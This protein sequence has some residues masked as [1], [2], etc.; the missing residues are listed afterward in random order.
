[1][2]ELKLLS[3]PLNY[4]NYSI[5]KVRRFYWKIS[6]FNVTGMGSMSVLSDSRS[7]LQS[8]HNFNKTRGSSFQN[9]RL[10]TTE[11]NWCSHWC[12]FQQHLS[13]WSISKSLKHQIADLIEWFIFPL[14]ESHEWLVLRYASEL[15]RTSL[16]ELCTWRCLFRWQ[17]FMA[18]Q[19]LRVPDSLLCPTAYIYTCM[20]TRDTRRDPWTSWACVRHV[21]RACN[22]DTM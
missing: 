4:S 7:C 19:S 3:Q 22:C 2:V 16:R 1:M 20:Q 12:S 21:H 8:T 13:L 18:G 10:Q 17:H 11:Q 5:S 14:Q 6:N 9:E 15:R